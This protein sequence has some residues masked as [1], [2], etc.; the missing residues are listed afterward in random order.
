MELLSDLMTFNGDIHG[1]NRH[2]IAKMKDSVLHL[3]SFEKTTDHLFNAATHSR[4]DQV[5]GVSEC[6]IMGKPIP[7][8]TGVMRLLHRQTTTM[9]ELRG[10]DDG[11]VRARMADHLDH[12]TPRDG[13]HSTLVR[14]PLFGAPSALR[15]PISVAHI[16][17]T[18]PVLNYDGA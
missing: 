9:P 7:L 5:K 14:R 1:I 12:T 11:S 6:I 18:P 2:G 15:E 3:A 10:D 4:H 13:W 16:P 17:A 8:G